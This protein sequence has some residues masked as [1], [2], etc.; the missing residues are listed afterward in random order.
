MYSVLVSKIVKGMQLVSDDVK[1]LVKAGSKAVI[2]PWAFPLELDAEKLMNEYFKKGEKK[3]NNYVE[4]L[5][6][7]GIKEEDIFIGNCY[8][9]SKELLKAKIKNSDILVLP[10]GNPEMFFTKVVQD[11]ELLY[12]IKYYQGIIIGE[13]AG[14]ELHLKRYFITAKNNYYKYY[15]WYDGF[16]IID[17][18]FYMDVHSIRKKFYLEKLQRIADEKNK[19]VYAIFDEGAIIYNRENKEIK[20]YGSVLEFMPQNENNS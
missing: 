15:A 20:K 4:A 10:G 18:P 2:L 14:C 12:D 16:G 19:K 1:K 3:Y 6:N 17:D 11:K 7:L 5:L 9:D 13:S 8:S